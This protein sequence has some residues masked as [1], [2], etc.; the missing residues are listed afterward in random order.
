MPLPGQRAA[1]ATL[2]VAALCSMAGITTGCGDAPTSD[3]DLA[4]GAAVRVEAHGCGPRTATGGGS[5][6]APNRVLTVAHVVA[7]AGEVE[8][9]FADGTEHEATVVGID[10]INDLAL[11]AVSADVR[12]LTLGS[13]RDGGRGSIAVWR[14]GEFVEA[15]FTA[16][17]RRTIHTDDIDHGTPVDRRGYLVRAD[18]EPGDSGSIL[19]ADG[20]AVAVAFARSTTD[21]TRTYA[22]DIAE[23]QR[24]IDEGSEQPVDLGRCPHG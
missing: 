3:A 19:V 22:T 9:V 18:I 6:V 17:A 20:V 11:V 23:A 13:L 1:H 21:R 5:F 16:A 8:V 24:M 4:I 2:M 7:G 10:R 15:P 14:G 12:P